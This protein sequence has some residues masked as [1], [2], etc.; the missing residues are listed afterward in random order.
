MVLSTNNAWIKMIRNWG[1]GQTII[2]P[3]W[4]DPM[5]KHQSLRLL[6]ILGYAWRQ[7]SRMAV[8]WEAPPGSDQNRCRDPQSNIVWSLKTLRVELGEGIRATKRIGTPK[9][10]QKSTNMNPWEA[11]RDWTTKQCIWARTRTFIHVMYQV[12]SLVFMWVFLQLE[13][14]LSQKPLPVYGICSLN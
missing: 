7:E 2:A 3:T 14:E 5:D 9:D 12:F 6:M 10:N 4:D 13:W 1:N 8:H 11:I